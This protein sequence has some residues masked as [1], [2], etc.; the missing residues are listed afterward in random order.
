MIKVK[1]KH[2]R[3]EIVDQCY[4]SI[5]DVRTLFEVGYKQ[6]RRIYEIADKID[7]EQLKNWRIQD[8]KVRITSVCKANRH[9][10]SGLAEANKKWMIGQNHP[11][12]KI[13]GRILN[14]PSILTE[15]EG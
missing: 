7:A 1:R 3:E 10:A 8:R 12:C 11:R 5:E 13:S 4:L 9:T 15:R 14:A 6:A 2:T